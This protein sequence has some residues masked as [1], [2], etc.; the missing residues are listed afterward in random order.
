MNMKNS[1][2]I[3]YKLILT[4]VNDQPAWP[5]FETYSI[6]FDRVNPAKVLSFHKNHWYTKYLSQ[7][8]F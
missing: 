8:S 3:S 1:N 7:K 2:K 5:S 6:P 4:I